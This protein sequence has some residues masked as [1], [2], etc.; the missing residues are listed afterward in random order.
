MLHG[1]GREEGAADRGRSEFAIPQGYVPYPQ[2]I[3]A[4][5]DL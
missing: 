3:E 2:K 4:L 1:V 5:S